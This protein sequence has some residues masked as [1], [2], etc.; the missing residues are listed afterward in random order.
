MQIALR[1]DDK[2]YYGFVVVIL[3][4]FNDFF[5]TLELILMIWKTSQHF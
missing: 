1:N 5:F 3:S 2:D 4:L